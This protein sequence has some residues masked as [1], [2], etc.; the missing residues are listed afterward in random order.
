M[1]EIDNL[2]AYKEFDNVRTFELVQN[3]WENSD[4]TGWILMITSVNP[5]ETPV[6][7]NLTRGFKFADVESYHSG[8]NIEI[9]CIDRTISVKK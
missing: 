2:L 6:Y 4:E 7:D 5:D 3:L 1:K 8:N 9:N